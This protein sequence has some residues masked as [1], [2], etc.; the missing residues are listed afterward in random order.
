MA[1]NWNDRVIT[2]STLPT[3]TS[4]CSRA[5]VDS[6]PWEIPTGCMMTDCIQ[7]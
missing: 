6:T 5:S 2:V 1:V 3:S 4:I 7:R